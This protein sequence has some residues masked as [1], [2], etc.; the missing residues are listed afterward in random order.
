MPRSIETDLLEEVYIDETSQTGQRFLVLGGLTIPHYLAEEFDAYIVKARTRKLAV[1]LT[2]KMTVSEMGWNN[3]GKGDFDVYQKVMEAYFSFAQPRL[4]TTLTRFE[5]HCSVIDT[6]TRGRHYSG[7]RGELGFNRE[8]YYHCMTI[9][10]RHPHNFFYVYP[11][12][13][14]TDQSMEEMR[15]ILN[16]GARRENRMRPTP[17]RRLQFRKSHESQAI[18]ISDLMI[19]ALAYRLNRHYDQPGGAD[20]KALCEYILKRGRYWPFITERGFRERAWGRFQV[21]FRRHKT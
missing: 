7:K 18:Q 6:Q 4:K 21:W 16:Y 15:K 9:A 3:I 13:R 17:F 11:D 19:G 10:R 2:D 14:Q 20:K 12:E 1:R 8:I 5:F